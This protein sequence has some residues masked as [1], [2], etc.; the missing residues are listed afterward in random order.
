MIPHFLFLFFF[1]FYLLPVVFS[2]VGILFNC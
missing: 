1:F 2:G